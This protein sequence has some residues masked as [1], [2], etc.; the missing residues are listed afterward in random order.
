MV[1]HIASRRSAQAL[2]AAAIVVAGAW[3][4][5][6]QSEG[7]ARVKSPLGR[8]PVKL[9]PIPEKPADDKPR[10]TTITIGK[11]KYHAIKAA[12]PADGV[13]W[14]LLVAP[15]GDDAPNWQRG[16]VLSPVP[17]A[18][19]AQLSA[20]LARTGRADRQQPTEIPTIEL[21]QTV[22]KQRM[23][24]SLQDVVGIHYHEF[25]SDDV[26]R[27]LYTLHKVPPDNADGSP[28]APGSYPGKP[29]TRIEATL[30]TPVEWHLD[31]TVV[32]RS[33]NETVP[34]K[35]ERDALCQ[36]RREHE[37]GHAAVS[38]QVLIDVLAGPQTWSVQYCT[39][40]RSNIVYYWK[41]ELIGRSW[42]GY[43]DGIGKLLTLRTT[44]ALVPPTRWSKLLPLPPER[45]TAEHL[46]SFNDEI[47][48]LGPIFAATDRAAQEAFHSH[49]GEYENAAAP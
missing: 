21:P 26:A 8:R 44:I 18:P 10:P 35:H 12:G 22:W 7:S 39:G 36:S 20:S 16:D 5:L 24:A 33:D 37:A 41:R 43:Q 42:D 28:A 19:T 32:V 25:V 48:K 46:Q 49:H 31:Q 15:A 13:P 1:H 2:I 11:W 40:R 9:W 3:P 34:V 23:D 29:G 30:L 17:Q 14:E 47:V 45:V 27:I 6:A 4:A 38:Q